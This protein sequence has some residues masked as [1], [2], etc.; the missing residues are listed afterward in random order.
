MIRSRGAALVAVAVTYVV[1]GLA[2]WVV[3]ALAGGLS[4]LVATLLADVAATL[5]VFGVSM[6]FDNASFYDP[7]WSV[8]PPVIAVAWAA[9]GQGEATRRVLV[10]WLLAAWGIRLTVNWVRTWSGI[11]HED[12]RYVMLRGQARH[13]R[14]WWL[15]D[16]TGIQ[17][18]PTL[19]V[20]LALL[21]AWPALTHGAGRGL[22]ALDVVA[23]VMLA[24][25]FL[26]EA[27]ADLQRH[28]WAARP[29]NAGR[30]IDVGVWRYSRH[31]NYL[32]EIGVW[33]GLWLFGLAADPGWWWTV[34]GP[35]AMVGLFAFASIP[36]MDRRSL[37]RRPGYAAH[38][39]A[40]PAL[41]PR[42][43]RRS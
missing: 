11:G 30:I 1:A 14:P 9:S 2:A 3:V 33:W 5:V 8:A 20:L 16:L 41:V 6:A 24:G 35:L 43:R 40:V 13:G 23:A 21:P 12:W 29:G 42:P 10:I 31:P 34:V 26:L 27:T 4:A 37:E 18:F 7:Y 15:I 36:M 38:M 17:L 22:G 25:A 32:G 39:A 28:R 19:I